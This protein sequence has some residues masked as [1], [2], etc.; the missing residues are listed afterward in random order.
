MDQKKIRIGIAQINTIVGDLKGNGALILKQMAI[1]GKNDVDILLFPEL[2][3]TG[4]PPEDLLFKESFIDANIE[5]VHQIRQ[6]TGEMI[7][8]LGF[9]DKVGDKYY[10]AAAILYRGQIIARYH[11]IALPNYGVFDEKRYFEP[12]NQLF[13]LNWNGIKLGLTICEDIWADLNLADALVFLNDVQIILNISA[14]PFHVGKRKVRE[15]LITNHAFSKRVQFVYTNLIGGQDELIFDGQSLVSDENGRILQRGLPFQEDF[16]VIDLE[17]EKVNQIRL[18][19]TAFLARKEVF[20][21][22]FPIKEIRLETKTTN[23][24]KIFLPNPQRTELDNLAEVYQALVLGTRDYTIKNGFQKVVLGLSGGIDSALCAAIAVDALGAENVMGVA[25][26]SQYSSEHSVQDAQKLVENLKCKFYIIPIQSTYQSYQAMLAEVFQDLSEDVTEENIQARIRGNIIMALSNKFGWL[27]IT[28]GNK[29]EVS[30]GYCTL[31]GDM[32]GGFAIIKDVPKT[33]VYQLAH[34]RNQMA[35]SFL[36]PENTLIKAPSAELRPG[37]FDEDSLPKY[38]LLDKILEAYVG[39]N[40]EL[41]KIIALGY[42]EDVVREVVRL[43]DKSEYK[44]R[45]SAPGIKITPRAFG[46]DRR[47]PLTNKYYHQ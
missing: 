45:Q 38:S 36:I 9:V 31:Y 12:G 3:V 6:H 16:F 40:F 44:R 23:S 35:N 19:D 13:S 5:V 27:A 34:Y 8:I 22:T 17:V 28:T 32:V 24:S 29:S 20:L 41:K 15:Q 10:N 42:P 43:V 46:K 25:M 37:Q 4:Y 18:E 47:M 2:T 30:V 33:M 39:L 11:K 1:A 26:P 14:S 7:V 21:S